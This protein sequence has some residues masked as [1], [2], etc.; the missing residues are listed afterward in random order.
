MRCQ[1]TVA[2]SQQASARLHQKFPSQNSALGGLADLVAPLA[3]VKSEGMTCTFL[4]AR[5]LLVGLVPRQRSPLQGAWVLNP[6]YLG[7]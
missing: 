5:Q 2:E 1:I 4:G 3:Q 7:R 6:D